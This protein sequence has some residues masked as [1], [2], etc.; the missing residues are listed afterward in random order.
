MLLGVQPDAP[1][2]AR[3]RVEPHAVG[4]DRLSGTVPT[5]KGPVRVAW[6]K[7]ADGSLRVAV[8]GPKDVPLELVANGR[9]VQAAD[10]R[11]EIGGA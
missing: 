2:W 9:T 1:G 4:L 5:P 8:E 3:I 7:R 6:E 10:G 11:A